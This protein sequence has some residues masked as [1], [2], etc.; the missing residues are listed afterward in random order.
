VQLEQALEGCGRAGFRAFVGQLVRIHAG[1]P[2]TVE[3]IGRSKSGCVLY[4]VPLY[5]L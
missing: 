4:R 1:S 3:A 5:R 2:G